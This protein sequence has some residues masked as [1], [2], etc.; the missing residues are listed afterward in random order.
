MTSVS[1]KLNRRPLPENRP[2]TSS[3]ANL[4][5]DKIAWAADFIQSDARD[6]GDFGKLNTCRCIMGEHDIEPRIDESN[7]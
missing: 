6:A 4:H 5:S 7:R 2:L 3:R 1:G